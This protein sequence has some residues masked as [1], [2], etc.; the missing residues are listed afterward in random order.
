M[1]PTLRE[2][3]ALLQ[4]E[5]HPDAEDR[6][7]QRVRERPHDQPQRGGQQGIAERLAAGDVEDVLQPGEARRGEAGVHQAVGQRVE[8]VAAAAGHHDQ[9]EQALGGL[10]DQRR[11][12]GDGNRADV[13][14][15]RG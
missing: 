11:A 4:R 7:E 10:F 13:S 8:L 9:Q 2:G 12:D 3:V 15:R 5:V 14:T 6:G 1:Q